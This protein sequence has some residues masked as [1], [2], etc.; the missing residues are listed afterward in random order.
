[1]ELKY[2]IYYSIDLNG[3]WTCFNTE[4]LENNQ[5]GNKITITGLQKNTPYYVAIVP[6]YEN[7]R[8]WQPLLRQPIQDNQLQS[9][10]MPQ[11]IDILHISTNKTISRK[12]E[13]SITLSLNICYQG[14]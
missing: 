14:V 11:S 10:T 4:P 7:E 13:H 12:S 9:A 2:N 1:M 8:T 3:P 6:G 5:Q